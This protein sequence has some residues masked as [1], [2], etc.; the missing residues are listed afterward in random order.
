MRCVAISGSDIAASKRI[1]VRSPTITRTRPLRRAS[2]VSA[3]AGPPD[4]IAPGAPGNTAGGRSSA[5]AAPEIAMA[6]TSEDATPA[7]RTN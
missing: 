2:D 5:A 3:S 1:G 6:K 7:A 4:D